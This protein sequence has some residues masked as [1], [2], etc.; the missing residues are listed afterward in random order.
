MRHTALRTSF[1][2]NQALSRHERLRHLSTFRETGVLHPGLYKQQIHSTVN[3]IIRERSARW[4]DVPNVSL[5]I[6]EE[7]TTPLRY[8]DAPVLRVTLFE[9]GDDVRILLFVMSHI[10][11]DVWSTTLFIQEFLS[12]YQA[13]C[14]GCAPALQAV[15]LQ[16]DEFSRRE[17]TRLSNGGF[18]QEEMY[19]GEVWRILPGAII[20]AHELPCFQASPSKLPNVARL[21][22][23]CSRA[24]YSAVLQCVKQLRVTRYVLFRAA[25]AVVLHYYTSKPSVAVWANFAN[26]NDL[27]AESLVGWCSNAHAVITD[28]DPQNDCSQLCAQVASTLR[29]AEAY[30]SLPS[31]AL[32]QRY[33]N[34][35]LRGSVKITFDAISQGYE[36]LVLGPGVESVTVHGGLQWIDLD[37]R[38]GVKP[39]SLLVATYNESRHDAAK[40][41]WLLAS[42]WRVALQMALDPRAKVATLERCLA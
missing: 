25:F 11:L 40:V 17:H 26:R 22:H 9:L 39:E 36:R 34:S 28:I 5:A 41:S 23:S 21:A 15:G 18:S 2:E 33:G 27:D 19:W 7:V 35:A 12:A 32:I 3:P 29:E 42:L 6:Q 31:A 1:T 30:A 8:D 4:L 24:E 20:T 14:S 16:Y 37:V 13:M 10:I 38:L